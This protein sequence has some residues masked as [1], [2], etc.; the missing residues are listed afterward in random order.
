MRTYAVTAL[1][2]FFTA[3]GMVAQIE[4]GSALEAARRGLPGGQES[5]QLRASKV[6]WPAYQTEIDRE[7]R[8]QDAAVQA[9]GYEL[10]SSIERYETKVITQNTPVNHYLY[11]R[12]LGLAK[13]YDRAKA[14]FDRAISL[15]PY[16]HWA[17][18]GLGTYFAMRDLPEPASQQFLK[19][20]ELCP[21]SVRASR[22][23]A[24]CYFKMGRLEDSESTLRRLLARDRA[25][26]DTWISLGQ[27]L[28]RGGKYA[29]AGEVLEEALKLDPNHEDIIVNLSRCYGLSDQPER[30]VGMLTGLVTKSPNA[31][32][33]HIQLAMLYERMGKNWKAADALE[34]VLRNLPVSSTVDRDKL[35]ET[36]T[37]L[38]SMPAETTAME[39]RKS[40]R[41]LVNDL[42]NS[43]EVD[44]R[45][46]AIRILGAIPFN[47]A[48][49]NG[50]V[51]N[52]VKDDDHM[53]RTM[54]VKLLGTWFVQPE[55]TSEPLIL[56]M[57]VLKMKDRNAQ[58]RGM[59]AWALA[60]QD[61]PAAV[62]PLVEALTERDPY[63][64]RQIHKALNRLT[65]AYIE[66]DVD[67]MMTSHRMTRLADAWRQWY[68]RNE[69]AYRRYQ[70]N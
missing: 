25:D 32:K 39:K 59:T 45:R 62:P 31:Y 60:E 33:A 29:R 34:S 21:D 9:G 58:V 24:L 6:H 46:R 68:K 26:L 49:I 16:F 38:R 54:A 70:K 52:A 53:V 23:L 8:A 12:I 37:E 63:A 55:S 50:A 14:E 43:V 66:V 27:V 4:P 69:L 15:D 28:M 30:A 51:L 3:S 42:R 41:D 13:Q 2:A 7:I 36:V 11:G 17:Y 44:K 20:L 65:F 22:G 48:E 47:H 35:T 61:H 18:H 67:E 57:L 40:W 56:P 10:D 64:F 5:P 1:V 19:C